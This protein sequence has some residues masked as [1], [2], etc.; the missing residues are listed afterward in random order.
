[1]DKKCTISDI[2]SHLKA[3]VEEGLQLGHNRTSCVKTLGTWSFQTLF[4]SDFAMQSFQFL[5]ADSC[6]FQEKEQ[7]SSGTITLAV[8]EVESQVK[9]C[10]YTGNNL[11]QEQ[12]QDQEQ[13]QNRDQNLDL[14]LAQSRMIPYHICL[15]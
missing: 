12:E 1:M 6:L 2:I 14:G 13:D 3:G 5:M 9:S 15:A 7:N 4:R 11:R 10:S 8:K